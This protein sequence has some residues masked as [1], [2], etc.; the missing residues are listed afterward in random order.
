MTSHPGRVDATDTTRQA[1]LGHLSPADPAGQQSGHGA[2]PAGATVGWAMSLRVAESGAD[3]ELWRQV[4]ATVMPEDRCPSVDD[5]VRSLELRPNRRL[6]LAKVDGE[7]VGSGIGDQSDEV[8]RATA[9]AR[10]LPERRRSGYG[11]AILEP[12]LDHARSL[13]LSS[14]GANVADEGS[15]AFAVRHGFTESDRQVEQVRVIGEEAWPS[16]VPGI[17]VRAVSERPELWSAAYEQVALDTVDDMALS[18]AFHLTPQD[19]QEGWMDTPTST[20][21]AL[22]GERVVG[23]AGLLSP[24]RPGRAEHTY[25]AVR[26]DH[27]GRGIGNLLKRTCLAWAAEHELTE[28][29]TWTQQHNAGMRTLNELLGYT[30][31]QVSVSMRRTLANR[32]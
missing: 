25:T 15:V 27:R 29:T 14:V 16:P 11:S 9:A 6:L 24:D 7:V 26:R 28:V 19:W 2:A 32:S 31:R 12:L 13:G 22:E 21:L 4:F 3:L 5:L 1:A 23:V 17:K 8:G 20:F 10:V 18:G 30:Y